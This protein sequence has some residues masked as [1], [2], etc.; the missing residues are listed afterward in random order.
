MANYGQKDTKRP[1]ATSEEPGAKIGCQEQKQGTVHALCTQ[2]HQA[3]HLSHP[4]DPT[5]GP[6]PTLT[7]YEEPALP[8][9]GSEQGDLLLVSLPPATAGAPVKPCLNF[10]S[11]LS[12]ISI[13]WGRPRTLVGISIGWAMDTKEILI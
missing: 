12:S 6:T 7:P 3:T 8:A 11:G 1:T 10:L 13:D 5:P 9:L 2:H 4:S